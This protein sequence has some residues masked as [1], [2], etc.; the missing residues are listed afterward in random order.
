[1][2]ERGGRIAIEADAPE[3][4]EIVVDGYTLEDPSRPVRVIAGTS[5]Q[6]AVVVDGEAVASEV[7]A[8]DVG[9]TESV[10]LERSG[11]DGGVSID[12]G[13]EGASPAKDWR[14]WVSL[15]VVAAVA[16]TIVIATVVDDDDSVGLGGLPLVSWD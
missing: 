2:Q 1:M 10:S 9:Q 13:N 6:V 11:S 14:F 3:N 8:V 4:A 5:H 16:L 12:W 7:V 15:G